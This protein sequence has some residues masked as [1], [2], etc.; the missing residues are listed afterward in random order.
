MAFATVGVFPTKYSLPVWVDAKTV[1]F[2]K[3]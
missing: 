3:S 1:N 2:V